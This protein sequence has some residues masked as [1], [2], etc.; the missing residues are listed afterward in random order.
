MKKILVVGH[1]NIDYYGKMSHNPV[2][3]GTSEI[4]EYS[5]SLGGTATNIAML[6][7]SKGADISIHSYVGK[8]FP[9]QYLN[10]LKENRIDLKYLILTEGY[11]PQCW[12]FENKN[13]ETYSFIYQG[14]M[15]KLPNY[16]PEEMVKTHDIIHLSTGDPEYMKKIHDEAI[17]NGKIIMFDPGPE[18]R[19]NHTAE[20]FKD[21]LKGC[22]FLFMN[23]FEE[24]IAKKYLSIVEEKEFAKYVPNCIVTLGKEGVRWISSKGVLTFPTEPIDSPKTV[25]A[26]DAFRGAFLAVY[27][28]GGSIE[29]AIKEGQDEAYK[30]I[31]NKSK[32][33]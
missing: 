4:T 31:L 3:D 30:S 8:D 2:A 29:N 32:G 16:V 20:T 14:V 17:S 12:I 24:S 5:Q 7:S 22:E 27:S 6:A 28:K 19:Y 33:I 18:I 26:G 9:V 23:K 1:V 11:T 21:I 15:K 25:G 10:K 13:G